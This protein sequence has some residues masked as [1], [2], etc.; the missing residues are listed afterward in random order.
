M[1]TLNIDPHTLM[2]VTNQSS[3][4]EL[5]FEGVSPGDKRLRVH[6]RLD[7][8]VWVDEIARRLHEYLAN[9]Q[10]KLNEANAAMKGTA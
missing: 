9:E 6:V 1:K 4:F 5:V 8:S 10:K 3:A 2:L 7:S